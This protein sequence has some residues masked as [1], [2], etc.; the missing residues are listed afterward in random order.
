VTNNDHSTQRLADALSVLYAACYHRL[1]RVAEAIVADPD[2]AHD[3]VQE[4]FARALRDSDEL[5][6]EKSVEAWLWRIV[7]NTARNNRRARRLNVA[8]DDIEAAGAEDSPWPDERVRRL[9]MRLP[10]RQRLVLFLRYYAD[11]SYAQIAAVLDIREG[12]VGAT[13]NQAHR[14]LARLLEEVPQ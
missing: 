7:V 14:S 2:L 3:V 11:L 13:L 9:I 6:A 5:R 4:A 10:E 8:L 12:T 1:L